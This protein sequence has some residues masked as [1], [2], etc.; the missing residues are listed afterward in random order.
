MAEIQEHLNEL[1]TVPDKLNNVAKSQEPKIF[2]ESVKFF[3]QLET[4]GDEVLVNENNINLIQLYPLQEIIIGTTFGAAFLDYLKSFDSHARD[5]ASIIAESMEVNVPITDKSRLALIG[6]KQQAKGV[7]TAAGMEAAVVAPIKLELS[8]T[9]ISGSRKA[10]ILNL[11]ETT[12]LTTPEA[13]SSL[14]L[15]LSRTTSDR[16]AFADRAFNQV[17]TED[18]N[19]EWWVYRGGLLTDSREFC[20]RR[21][22]K[23]FHTEE[24]REWGDPNIFLPGFNGKGKWQGRIKGT[25]QGNIMINLGG[26]NCKHSIIPTSVFRVPQD[27]ILRNIDDGNFVPT[28]AERKQLGL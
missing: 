17:I 6:Y 9:I 27:V 23:F 12:L 7:I 20:V 26:F 5:S 2:S 18:L 22:G 11:L 13:N 14:A 28:S 4:E 24:V 16:F 21:N 1:D 19:P 8:N 15:H 25:N 3:D 10:D